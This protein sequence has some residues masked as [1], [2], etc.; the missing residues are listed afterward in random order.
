MVLDARPMDIQG[1][2]LQYI[3]MVL[4]D[5]TVHGDGYIIPLLLFV[6]YANSSPCDC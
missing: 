6:N 3:E 1:S 4:V 5:G 2:L